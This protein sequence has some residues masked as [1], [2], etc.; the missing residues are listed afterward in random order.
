VDVPP[1]PMLIVFVAAEVLMF[2]VVADVALKI[3]PTVYKSDK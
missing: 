2:T 3:V 1:V